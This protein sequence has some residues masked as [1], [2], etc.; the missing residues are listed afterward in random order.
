MWLSILLPLLLGATLAFAHGQSL[1][2]ALS[3]PDE[4]YDP[5]G[6]ANVFSVLEL[7]VYS[8]AIGLAQRFAGDRAALVSALWIALGT[9]VTFASLKLGGA[10]GHSMSEGYPLALYPFGVGLLLGAVSV[11]RAYAR[12]AEGAGADERGGP[13]TR[14]AWALVVALAAGWALLAGPRTIESMTD[15]ALSKTLSE[16]GGPPQWL[17]AWRAGELQEALGGYE[18]V[19]WSPAT[20]TECR[21]A[22]AGM[23]IGTAGMLGGDSRTAVEGLGM[24]AEAGCAR[25]SRLVAGETL[26]GECDNQHQRVKRLVDAAGP[27]IADALVQERRVRTLD[28][29]LVVLGPEWIV[30]D[31][32]RIDRQRGSIPV[33]ARDPLLEVAVAHA[34]TD[35]KLIVMR[36]YVTDEVP[37]RDVHKLVGV[38]REVGFSKVETIADARD[39]SVQL[40]LPGDLKPPHAVEVQVVADMDPGRVQPQRGPGDFVLRLAARPDVRWH[41]LRAI[42]SRHAGKW[43]FQVVTAPAE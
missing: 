15:R 41:T 27:E 25:P 1:V 8:M 18:R 6:V 4:V 38:A 7:G 31:G 22:I 26:S 20:R 35:P 9:A 5:V 42:M 32:T 29:P 16:L 34:R 40:A 39:R 37:V 43:A 33:T 36:L 3:V 23:S 2:S 17:A 19:A 30:I 12:A 11:R 28:E 21:R 10:G 13:W 14:L 24:C